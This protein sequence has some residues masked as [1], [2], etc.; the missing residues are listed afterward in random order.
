[1]TIFGA[2]LTNAWISATLLTLYLWILLRLEVP[3]R[4]ALAC[5]AMLG[6][7]TLVFAHSKNLFSHSLVAL[8]LLTAIAG[9]MGQRRWNLVGGGL[10]AG[11]AAGAMVLTR[12]QSAVMLPALCW[13]AWRTTPSRRFLAFGAPAA[14]GLGAYFL[15]NLAR[16]GSFT[17][18]GY[19]HFAQ[20]TFNLPVGLYGHFFSVGRSVFIYSPPLVLLGWGLGPFRRRLGPELGLMGGVAAPLVLL[21]ASWSSWHGDWCYGNRFL[22]PL[23]PVALLALPMAHER[24]GRRPWGG[25]LWAAVGGLGFLVQVLGLLPN[26]AFVHHGYR[27]GD[28]PDPLPYLFTPELSQL[29][30]YADAI[31]RGYALDPWLLRAFIHSPSLGCVA[32]LPSVLAVALGAWLLRQGARKKPSNPTGHQGVAHAPN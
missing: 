13:Y 4:R 15:W 27:F 6:A 18:F 31:S 11:V 12:V 14:A 5:V 9:L 2:A 10:I 23:V 16:F 17:E 3:L 21:Y 28:P 19:P 24:L 29:A 1:M 26:I 32:M 8:L 30:R 25:A 7:S 20:F 22:L